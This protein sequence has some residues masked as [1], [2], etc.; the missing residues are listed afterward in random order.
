MYFDLYRITYV[1]SFKLSEHASSSAMRMFLYFME[2][3]IF[4]ETKSKLQG[5]KLTFLWN[6]YL[7]LMYELN[8]L[9]AN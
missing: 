9:Y 1:I 4:Y 5:T 2:I 8:L 7:R 6:L 3:S